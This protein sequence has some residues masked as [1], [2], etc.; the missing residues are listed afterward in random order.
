[1]FRWEEQFGYQLVHGSRNLDALR[2]GF[3]VDVPAGDGVVLELFQPDLI[4][5]EDSRWLLGLLAIASEHSRYHLACGRRF[6]TLLVLPDHSPMIGQ[7]IDEIAVPCAYWS[8]SNDVHIFG[9]A[10]V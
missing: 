5:R 9:K 8:S 2:D 6:F 4:W 7:K 1:M 3:E 10:E